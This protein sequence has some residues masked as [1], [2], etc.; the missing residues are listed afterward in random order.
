[1]VVFVLY[2][3]FWEMIDCICAVCHLLGD[4]LCC[5]WYMSYFGI[6]PVLYSRRLCKK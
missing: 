6:W 1:V 4:N 3:I 5:P 2:V